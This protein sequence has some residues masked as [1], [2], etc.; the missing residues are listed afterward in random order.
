MTFN[1]AVQGYVGS[2]DKLIAATD[3]A[4]SWVPITKMMD[5]VLCEGKT[6]EELIRKSRIL[7]ERCREK[8]LFFSYSK[9]QC[10]EEVIYR[11]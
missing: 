11:G 8:K 9:V 4:L 6:M 5:N 7:F 1:G 10:G 2:S 3:V